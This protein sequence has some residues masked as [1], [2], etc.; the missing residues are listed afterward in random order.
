[1]YQQNID[2][3]VSHRIN[4]FKSSAFKSLFFSMM[5]FISIL[6]LNYKK[7]SKTVFIVCISIIVTGDLW[8][9]SKDYLNNE[10]HS[11]FDRQMGMSGKKFWQDEELKK[12]PHSPK[13]ADIAIRDIELREN[14]DLVTQMQQEIN[15]ISNEDF[16]REHKNRIKNISTFKLLNFNTNYRVLEFGNPLNTART[17]YLH[18][19]IGGYSAVKVKRTQEM[20]DRYFQSNYSVLTNALNS[21]NI[22]AMKSAHFFNMLNTK[23][24]IL[25]LNSS[26]VVGNMNPQKPDEK[27]GVL[28]NP[29]A[30]GNAWS[31][32]N[33]NWVKNADEEI[34]AVGEQNFDPTNT[35]VI[36]E[37]FKDLIGDELT[38][39]NCAIQLIDYKP[40]YLKYTANADGEALVVFS[41]IFYDKGWKAFIDGVEI[42][43]FR[44]NY[45]LRGLKISSGQHDV[46]FKFDLPIYQK[47]SLIS[48]TSSSIIILLFLI[49]LIFGFIDREF[50]TI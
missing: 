6:A 35:V 44:A 1:M 5:I 22:P 14:S 16:K 43:H 21:G 49:L 28:P 13:P 8:M 24:Y 32:S 36:D 12:F 41:E 10:N 39:A 38:L 20:I 46:E 25:D 37:R 4:V 15:R 34:A 45:I 17:S 26:G 50:P 2:E 27:P 3:L 31:V 30:L 19:S 9:T 29:F 11:T 48:L 7:I 47:A 33:V 40:N 42:P 18:K 23:Y